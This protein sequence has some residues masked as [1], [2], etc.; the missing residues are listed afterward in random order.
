MFRLF[1]LT[2]DFSNTEFGESGAP[3]K[4]TPDSCRR[5]ASAEKVVGFLWPK[6]KNQ[7]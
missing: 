1:G 4:L 2:R 3:K 6:T 7:K 5:A